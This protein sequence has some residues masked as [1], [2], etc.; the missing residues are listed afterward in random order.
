MA[1]TDIADAT[2]AQDAFGKQNAVFRALRDNARDARR[3]ILYTNIASDDESGGTFANAPGDIIVNFPDIA[4]WTGGRRKVVVEISKLVSGGATAEARVT[5]GT[6]NGTADSYT[7]GT[8]DTVQI[9]V[10]EPSQDNWR[11]TRRTFNIQHRISSGAGTSTVNSTN[12]HTSEVL[13]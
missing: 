9:E 11:N 8:V 2:V 12:R 10:E 4:M 3:S 6:T 7:N 5:D 13:W 1:W